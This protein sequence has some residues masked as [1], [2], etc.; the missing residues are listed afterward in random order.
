MKTQMAAVM[1]DREVAVMVVA[2]TTTKDIK[3]AEIRA[4][5]IKMAK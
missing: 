3:M 2:A 4:T 5:D 1:V